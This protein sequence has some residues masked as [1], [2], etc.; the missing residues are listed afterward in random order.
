MKNEELALISTL[1]TEQAKTLF[2]VAALLD[3]YILNSIDKNVS[4]NDFIQHNKDILNW[5]KDIEN[6]FFE[7][8]NN[9]NNKKGK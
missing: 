3:E 2:R 8:T 4:V 6:E 9:K 7:I 1:K 5:A